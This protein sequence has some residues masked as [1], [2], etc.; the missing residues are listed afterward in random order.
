V[1]QSEAGEHARVGKPGDRR[2]A[3]A[4][5]GQD[6]EPARAGV[7]QECAGSTRRRARARALPER[8]R[9]VYG[10]LM[11]AQRG[12]ARARMPWKSRGLV[13]LRVAGIAG[14]VRKC[15][16]LVDVVGPP[17]CSSTDRK[18]ARPSA[19]SVSRANPAVHGGT[20]VTGGLSRSRGSGTLPVLSRRSALVF[21]ST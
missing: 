19:A 12:Q 3:V 1:G 17:V 13:A 20:S 10:L 6:H 8:I 7:P 16:R 21:H 14:R 11:A 18:C 2:H 5:K 4:A 15:R 9:V